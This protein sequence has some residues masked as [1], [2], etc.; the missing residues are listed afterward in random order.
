M[1]ITYN[2]TQWAKDPYDPIRVGQFAVPPGRITT[3]LPK[4]KFMPSKLI[5]TFDMKVVPGSQVNEGYCALSYSWNQSG[6]IVLDPL[7]GKSKRKDQGKHK[8]I[9]KV[10]SEEFVRFETIIQQICHSFNIKYIWYDQLCINQND[11]EEKHREL[12]HI[13]QIYSS[14]YY[15]I[16][17]VPEFSI[18]IKS[19]KERKRLSEQD[20]AADLYCNFL[21]ALDEISTAQWSKRLWTLTEAIKSHQLVYV[22]RNIHV[23]SDQVVPGIK[24]ISQMKQRFEHWNVNTVLFYAHKRIST[25][26]HDRVFALANLFPDVME[27]LSID[28]NQS[29]EELMIRFYERLAKRDIT[30]LFFGTLNQCK[31]KGALF[32]NINDNNNDSNNKAIDGSK[33]TF[34]HLYNELPSWTGVAGEHRLFE[35]GETITSFKNYDVVGRIMRVTCTS[36]TR[37]ETS[38]EEELTVKYED[39]PPLPSDGRNSDPE[40]WITT[41]LPGQSCSKNVRLHPSYYDINEDDLLSISNE[42]RKLSKFMPITKK[43]LRWSKVVE[44]ACSIEFDLTEDIDDGSDDCIIL[45]GIDFS[46]NYYSH[47][48][49]RYYPVIKK[50]NNY[51]KVIGTCRIFKPEYFFSDC[52]LLERTFIIH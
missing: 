34:Q 17:L 10:H 20:N 44:I 24:Y 38:Y 35:W 42:L 30:I 41:Q 32:Q 14:A 48:R 8:L 4:P 39:L 15:T 29:L 37:D 43:K 23:Y 46:S 2:T 6:D 3:A 16:A 28:Y 21:D 52:I 51:F 40:L 33:N 22:G 1:Y 26:D 31:D 11:F 12:R 27:K 25:N 45:S 47:F 50:Q 7:T 13:H 5:R 18:K 49:K 19:T 36:I 9:R